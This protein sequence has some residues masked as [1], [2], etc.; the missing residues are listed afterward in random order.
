ML[1]E[2]CTLLPGVVVIDMDD[3]VAA[4][5]E[6]AG[7]DLTQTAA[8]ERWPA[9]ND[10]C[11]GFAVAVLRAGHD[12]LLLSPLNPAEMKSSTEAPLLGDVRWAVLDSTDTTRRLRLAA[13]LTDAQIEDALS[14]AAAFRALD[15]PLLSSDAV[16]V[17][18]TA[19]A[20]AEWV[21]DAL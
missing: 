7:T 12:T 19:Q 13:R 3:F 5:S 8:A 2:V 14:D 17:E 1:S 10:L 21:L 6:L 9:Y 18:S 16:T 20:V 15:L 4:A 11:L